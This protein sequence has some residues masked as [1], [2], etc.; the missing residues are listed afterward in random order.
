MA[1]GRRFDGTRGGERAR[2]TRAAR[3]PRCSDRASPG[4]PAL[5][6]RAHGGPGAAGSALPPSTP[7]SYSWLRVRSPRGAPEQSLRRHQTWL[8]SV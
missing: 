6:L 2:H 5:L 7:A 3:T 8:A 1:D 4:G